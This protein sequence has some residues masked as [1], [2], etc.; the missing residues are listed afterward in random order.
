MAK[1]ARKGARLS[2]DVAKVRRIK[3]DLHKL[4]RKLAALPKTIKGEFSKRKKQKIAAAIQLLRVINHPS[5]LECEDPPTE[6]GG[7]SARKMK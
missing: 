2:P 7:M 1:R 3:R 4:Q 6:A 5:V